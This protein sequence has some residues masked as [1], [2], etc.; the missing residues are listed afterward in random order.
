MYGLKRK[1][2]LVQIVGLDEDVISLTPPLTFSVQ[3]ADRFVDAL[4]GVLD[5]LA[6]TEEGHEWEKSSTSSKS[7]GMIDDHVDYEEQD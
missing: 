1:K 6:S 2:I 4:G 7:M 5:E 3:D